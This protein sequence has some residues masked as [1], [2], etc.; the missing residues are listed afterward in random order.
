V[1][2]IQSVISN[3]ILY[4]MSGLEDSSGYLEMIEAFRTQKRLL[5]KLASFENRVK[6]YGLP[7]MKHLSPPDL[8]ER[9]TDSCQVL[10][11]LWCGGN[12]ESGLNGICVL[13]SQKSETL[14]ART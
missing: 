14:V 7:E 3:Q 2:V 1:S 5:Q 10:G 4:M 8:E 11:K 9:K 6:G 13:L 12:I